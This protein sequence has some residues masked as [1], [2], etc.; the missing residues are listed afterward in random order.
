MP[1][2]VRELENRLEHKENTIQLQI[3][4]LDEYRLDVLRLEHQLNVLRQ[5]VKMM[6]EFI[7]KLK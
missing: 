2:I 6:Q 5:R 7:N 3:R 1:N 4:V